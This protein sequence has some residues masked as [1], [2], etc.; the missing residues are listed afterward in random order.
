MQD[1]DS[2]NGG[3]Y[4]FPLMYQLKKKKILRKGRGN[5]PSQTSTAKQS[6]F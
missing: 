6:F 1:F 4:Y 3:K 5:S 2:S